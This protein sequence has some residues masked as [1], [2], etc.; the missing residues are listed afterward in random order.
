MPR[1]VRSRASTDAKATTTPR[2]AYERDFIA[3]TPAR[4]DAARN[5]VA[6]SAINALAVHLGSLTDRR[7]T[8]IVAAEGVGASGS[9]PRPGIPADARHDHPVGEPLQRL[10]LS[11]RSARRRRPW[12]GRTLRRARGRDRRRTRLPPTPTRGLRR[13]AA[14]ASAYYLLSFRTA[15]PD[16]GQ[17]RALQATGE[18]AGRVGAAR[19]GYWTASPDEALRTALIAKANEPKNGGAAGTGA[20][21][22][23]ADSPL[24]RLSRGENGKTRVTFVWEPAARVPGD[25]RADSREARRAD[26]ARAG[27]HGGVRRPV[28][29]DRAGGVDDPAATPARAVFDVPPGRLRLRMSIEDAA[30]QV[31]DQDV[32]EISVRDLR[33]DVALG[34]P[35][36]LRARNA[37]RIPRPRRRSGGAGRV[38]RVQPHRAPADPLSGLRPRRR[39]RR[40][41]P[42]ASRPHRPSDA[43]PAR[44]RRRRRQATARSICR[45]PASP[46]A[47]MR[48]R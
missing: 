11:V 27:R 7:K 32:R 6:L 1:A 45:S 43:R 23:P 37:P 28:V 24:V 42:R 16:D 34:T 44:S 18:A 22:Q 39:S 21:R 8:L 26:R 14:D 36:V 19:K 9:P 4:I 10:G 31:I 17:F 29:A 13:A 46:T 48:S 47:S 3:G 38:A 2:N 5:Q 33:G 20:A 35:E 15:H 30:A 40:P 12:R 25:R 41:C